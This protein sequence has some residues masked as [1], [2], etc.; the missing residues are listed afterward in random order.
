M[1]S[2]TNQVIVTPFKQSYKWACICLSKK[3]D[4]K[5]VMGFASPIFEIKVYEI[6]E[7]RADASLPNN[8]TRGN[9][10]SRDIFFVPFLEA[11]SKAIPI[12]RIIQIRLD[13]LV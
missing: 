1:A 10:I 7:Y 12:F 13:F 9:S 11:A 6:Y 5:N 2:V 3:V 4:D 8:D